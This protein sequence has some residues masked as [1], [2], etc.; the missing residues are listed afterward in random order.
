MMFRIISSVHSSVTPFAILI[1]LKEEDEWLKNMNYISRTPKN[2]NGMNNSFHVDVLI[3]DSNIIFK[4][5]WVILFKIRY[6]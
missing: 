1:S 2:V 3:S 6:T 4:F 5:F